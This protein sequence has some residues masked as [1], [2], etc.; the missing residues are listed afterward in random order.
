MQDKLNKSGYVADAIVSFIL[1]GNIPNDQES[2]CLNRL[3]LIDE[4]RA[5][6]KEA[7]LPALMTSLQGNSGEVAGLY[8]SLL[9]PYDTREDVQDFLRG[10]W[11]GASPLLKAHLMW[12]IL[13]APDLPIE[14]H[15]RIFDFILDNWNVF[16]A[17]VLKFM[18]PP[19]SLLENVRKRIAD[20][21]YPKSKIWINLCRIA[22]V[23]KHPE[24]SKALALSGLQMSDPFARQVAQTLLDRFF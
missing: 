11:E 17:V 12:R 13:D 3:P 2:D 5:R 21:S 1:A 14:W 8:L 18:G 4:L 24:A 15:Q 10:R 9:K 16:Q 19:E 6:I 22:T 7:D 23:D 20:P